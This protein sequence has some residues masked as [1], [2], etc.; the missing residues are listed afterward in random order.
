MVAIDRVNEIFADARALKNSALERLDAGDIRDA[1][2]KAWG[3]TKRATDALVLAR[4]DVEP[5]KT[6][7]TASGLHRLA[8]ID[9]QVET[10][11]GRY[12]TRAD[13]LH[14]Q[15]FYLGLRDLVEDIERRIRE[16]ADYI[17]DSENLADAEETSASPSV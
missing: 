4:L 6:P 11:I 5:E 2:E 8:S 14:G 13:F 15:C 17:R 3:A 7:D 9:P 16:T 12:H 1:A 10:L